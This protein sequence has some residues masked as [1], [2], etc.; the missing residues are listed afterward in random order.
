MTMCNG[1]AIYFHDRFQQTTAVAGAVAALY[2][3][4]AVFARGLGGWVSD[5]LSEHL[6]MKGRLWAQMLSMI[7]Q[8]IFTI[9]WS[10]LDTLGP[11]IIMMVVVSILVQTS[12]GTCF[13]IVPYV[14]GQNTG[15]VAG[16][17]GA[18]GK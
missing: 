9:W 3:T 12:I 11:S 10:R 7:L 18:G 13:S 8:G 16:I 17:V 4:L 6:S 1:A 14:D 5:A 15:S 2:G